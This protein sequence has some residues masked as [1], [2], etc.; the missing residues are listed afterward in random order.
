MRRLQ[1]LVPLFVLVAVATMARPALAFPVT[2]TTVPEPSS[3][4]V[5][6]GIA[7]M[8]LVAWLIHGRKRRP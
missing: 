2:N 8:S 4:F 5:F 3:I 6:G 7:A 1:Y